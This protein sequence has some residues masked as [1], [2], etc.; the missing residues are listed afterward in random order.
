MQKMIY[1]KY[2]NE[3]AEEFQIR[4]DICEEKNRSRFVRKVACTDKSREHLQKIEYN[5]D[6]LKQMFESTNIRI[7]ECQIEDG[8]LILEYLDGE[9]LET[10]INNAIEADDIAQA[11]TLI[12][13]YKNIIRTVYKGSEIKYTDQFYR[14]FGECQLPEQLIW[15]RNLDIDLILPNIIIVGDTWNVIDYEWTFDFPIPLNFLFYRAIKCFVFGNSQRAGALEEILYR[16]FEITKDERTVYDTMEKSFQRYTKGDLISVGEVLNDNFAEKYINIPSLLEQKLITTEV[17]WES[18]DGFSEIQ[19]ERIKTPIEQDIRWNIDV[20]VGVENIRIDPMMGSGIVIIHELVMVT[21]DYE[22]MAQ[23]ESNGKRI[24]DSMFL[25]VSDDPQLYIKNWKNDT[26][27][28][29]II[30]SA[31][32]IEQQQLENI[33]E[34]V[35][36][37]YQTI[38]ENEQQCRYSQK[39]IDEYAVMVATIQ[40][41]NE[42]LKQK[43][44]RVCL[45]YENSRSWKMT[46]CLRGVMAFCREHRRVYHVLKAG[47]ILLKYGPRELKEE[48]KGYLIRRNS[49]LDCFDIGIPNVTHSISD[50]EIIYNQIDRMAKCEKKIAVHVHLYYEDLLDEFV[51]YLNNIPYSFDVF[52]SCQASANKKRI[53]K[54]LSRISRANRIVIIEC[55]NR[56]RDIAPLYVWL[57]GEIKNYDYFLHVHSKKSLY[58]GQE[59]VG[60]RRYSLN[61]LLG[62]TEIVQRIFTLLESDRN[63]GLVYPDNHPDVPT[64]AYS[65]LKNEAGG[66]QLLEDLHVPFSSGFFLYPAGSFFWAKTDALKPLFDREFRIE[67]FPEE[68]G[69]TDGTLAHVIER[70]TS[71]ISKNR[72][73]HDAIVDYEEGIIRIDASFKAFRGYGYQCVETLYAELKE[74][75]TVSFDIFDTLITRC[76]MEPDDLFY[77]MGRRIRNEYGVNIDFFKRRKQAEINAGQKQGIR[78]TIYDIYDELGKSEEIG[79]ELAQELLQ[80][81]IAM[82]KNLIIPRRDMVEVFNKLKTNQN[83]LILVSDMYLPSSILADILTDCGITGYNEMIISCECGYRKDADTIWD[84]VFTKYGKDSFVHV[85]DN[86]RS[87]WQTLI[88]RGIGVPW[89]MSSKDEM[90]FTRDEELVRESSGNCIKSIEYG[91]LFNQGMYNSP[92]VL[93]SNG[94][95]EFQNAWT[96]GFSVF[97]PLFYGFAHWLNQTLPNDAILLFLSREGFLLKQVYDIV[98]RSQKEKRVSK[99][100]LT[101]RRAASVASI[102]SWHDIKEILA[103]DY[104]GNVGQLLWNRL[105]VKTTQKYAEQD[106]RITDDDH[107]ALDELMSLMMDDENID[108]AQ[109]EREKR[110]YLKYIEQII[111]RREWD[112]A[113]VV[114]VGYAG[115]IQYYLAKIMNQKLAGAYLASFGNTKP[116]KIGCHMDVMYKDTTDFNRV[117]FLTQLFLEAALQAP[118]GQLI[119]MENDSFAGIQPR[120]KNDGDVSYDIQRLQEGIFEYCRRRA[121]LQEKYQIDENYDFS[122]AEKIYQKYVDGK[123]LSKELA[124]IFTVEDSYCRNRILQ[125]DY[126]TNSWK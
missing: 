36:V 11:I 51:Y 78:T 126:E 82:E 101:S 61:A 67:D 18:G 35:D 86:P 53:R 5:K 84:Y 102:E 22:I 34:T 120:Y 90:R 24:G 4:T 1:S 29:R 6:V 38:N 43:I 85:G 42:H 76:L 49:N 109:F 99:Y 50:N 37:L 91:L 39:R 10:L 122:I 17:F 52:V 40:G 93:N 28:I 58:T 106:I 118:C 80:M 19:K 103:R 54:H 123:C 75:K 14:I 56:G 72:G 121:F 125:F 41:E 119:C 7:N 27:M 63:I 124:S 73:Y 33:N 88:D 9:S 66:R 44:N 83:T 69:Q 89:I 65:W 94:M 98:C 2:S 71:L 16:E 104:D 87:D 26:K 57:A 13:Q 31:I 92:F 48:F 100:F 81:E 77:I 32:P 96:M 20:P 108:F 110:D 55:G 12:T 116:D 112:K 3:R 45:S 107:T 46:R 111:P 79:C 74:K 105:G 47:K 68:Q 115:T 70:S 97:G 60:W 117:I 23:V 95:V 15:T 114:D 64:M 113:V 30:M 8:T 62:S 25:F 59:R 21:S